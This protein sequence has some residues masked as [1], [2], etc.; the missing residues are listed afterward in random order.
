MS[1]EAAIERAKRAFG[2]SWR[3]ELISRAPGRLELLG[4]HVDYNGGPVLA[5]AIDRFVTASACANRESV[6]T[7]RLLAIDLDQD[8]ATVNTLNPSVGDVDAATTPAD[9]LG[10]ILQALHESE[11]PARDGQEIVVTGDVPLGFGMSSSAAL[12]VALTNLLADTE[13]SS[14]Q[15]VDIARRAEHLTGAP[16]G[17]MDQ[18]I[19]VAGGVILFD[20]ATGEVTPINPELGNR[21]FAVANSGVYHALNQSAYPTRVRES[22]QALDALRIHGHPELRRL[23]DLDSATWQTL[24]A[25]DLSW[26]PSPLPDRVDHV[27]SETDRVRQGVAAIEHQDWVEFGELMSASG[28]SSAISYDISHPVVEELVSILM[29]L[30]GVLGARMMGGGEGGPALALLHEDAVEDIKKELDESFFTRH[31]L[32]PEQSL[33]VCTFGP[34]ASLGPQ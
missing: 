34:G 9:Y 8:V 21:V 26:L 13:L 28:R 6:G 4:N 32:E 19:S 20:G 18:S 29:S 30:P 22:Q 3:P 33:K 17:A 1:D 7:T 24:R 16:V 11:L 10:G 5:A 12:C 14:S 31:D 27:V 15:I 25:D 23:T 2:P